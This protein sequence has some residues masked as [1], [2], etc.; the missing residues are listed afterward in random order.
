MKTY[1]EHQV[2]ELLGKAWQ[3]GFDESREGF[4]GEYPHPEDRND[5]D[6]LLRAGDAIE[7]ILADQG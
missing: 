1:T 6:M 2:R 3:A 7:S 4:N 5:K